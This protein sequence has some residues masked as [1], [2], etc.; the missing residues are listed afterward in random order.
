M[1]SRQI[2]EDG[3][4][5][6]NNPTWHAEDAGW[7]AGQVLK[8]LQRNKLRPRTVCEIGCGSGEILVQL[9]D[10]MDRDVQFVGYEVS[11][12][13]FE[14]CRAREGDR[15]SF[16]NADAFEDQSDPYDVTMAIDVIEHVEDVFGFLRKMRSHGR[17][18]VFH[19]PLDV[20]VQTVLRPSAFAISRKKSGHIH[21]FLKE[22]ALGILAETGYEVVDWFYTRG[23]IE[24]PGVGLK[25][26]LLR[27]PRALLF[28]L[29]QDFAVRM[30]GG[31]SLMVL[32]R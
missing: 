32:A 3:S 16:H 8:L 7:K 26:R 12:Q 14:L 31:F 28:A 17:D 19:I 2:Y 18:K 10:H 30:L 15:L 29:H 13:A 4:Y 6:R 5:L 25:A 23:S 9:A 20:C 11:P 27:G 22:T 1:S 24:L 21:T